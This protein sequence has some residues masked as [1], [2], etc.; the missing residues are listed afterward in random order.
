MLAKKKIDYEALLDANPTK[1]KEIINDEEINKLVNQYY[2]LNFEDVIS[3]GI[4]TRFPVFNL[5]FENK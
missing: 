2:G 1:F 5:V 3:G 4:K